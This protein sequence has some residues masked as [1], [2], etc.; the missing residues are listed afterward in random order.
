[1]SLNLRLHRQI[2]IQV[3][4]TVSLKPSL[5]LESSEILA[6]TLNE[7]S[8]IDEEI[9]FD[10]FDDPDDIRQ[11]VSRRESR[12]SQISQASSAIKSGKKRN[13]GQSMSK[14][15]KKGWQRRWKTSKR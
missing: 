15:W 3:A 2:L 14:V 10:A 7:L 8:D 1:M 13:K 12:L 6:D 4:L 11:R 9:N 5:S